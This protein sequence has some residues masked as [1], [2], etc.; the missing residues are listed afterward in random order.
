[1]PAMDGVDVVKAVKHMR[2]DIDVIV[3][4]GFATVETAVECMKFG[5][6]DY[7]QKPFTEDELLAFVKK[8]LIRRQDRIAK[9]LKPS[10]HVSHLPEADRVRRS[11]FSIPGGVFIAPGHTWAAM[12]QEGAVKVGMDDFAK[13]LL[14]PVDGIE[15]PP[16]GM[17]VKAGQPLFVVRQK[18]RRV[19]F[20]SPISGRVTKTNA[21]LAEDP[22]A[23]EMTPYAKNWVC[24]IDAEKLDVE[25]PQLKI[26]KAAVAMFEED[27]DKFRSTMKGMLGDAATGTE[28]DDAIYRG[29]LSQL[30]D[31][32][33]DRVAKEFFAR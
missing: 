4:T 11:E 21:M 25:I 13:K 5:A 9:L 27:I 3:I 26:G 19:Q 30:N 18:K 16:V 33:S 10:V 29:E 7:V 12:S 2:P 15:F 1:M 23:L 28:A 20:G 8:T 6:T 24:V 17:T 32:Q 14:G 22:G 31:D